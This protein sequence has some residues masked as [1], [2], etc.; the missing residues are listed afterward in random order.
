MEEDEE[1]EI[2]ESNKGVIIRILG[3]KDGSVSS[4]LSGKSSSGTSSSGSLKGKAS[5]F[6]NDFSISDAKLLPLAA[7][8]R[9]NTPARQAIFIAIMGADDADA[10]IERILRLDLK[11][12]A[13]REIIRVLLDCCAQEAKYNEFYDSVCSSLCT[14]RPSFKF[15]VQL[16]LWDLFKL[17]GDEQHASQRRV[18]NLAML[19]SNLILG[20]IVSLTILKPLEAGGGEAGGSSEDGDVVLASETGLFFTKALISAILSKA[21][22]P[23]DVERVFEKC[24]GSGADRSVIRDSLSIF[25]QK[26]IKAKKLVAY[27]NLPMSDAL[28]RIKAAINALDSVRDLSMSSA[29]DDDITNRSKRKKARIL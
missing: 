16:A 21:K 11:G 5:P 1:E 13:E 28:K 22:S 24:G 4:S 7:K 9:M 19:L 18:Y 25:V 6:L 26:H 17:F 3:E 20:N 2:G 15:T 14:L 27:S 12:P 23:S 10:A 29:Y 8:M